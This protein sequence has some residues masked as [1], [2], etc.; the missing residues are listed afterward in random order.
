MAQT[1]APHACPM[2]FQTY[3]HQRQFEGRLA[4]AQEY[5]RA[6]KEHR[7]QPEDEQ[8]AQLSMRQ[9]GRAVRL[10][11]HLRRQEDEQEAQLLHEAD[12]T[13]RLAKL[14][15]KQ[16]ATFMLNC[17]CSQVYR[18]IKVAQMIRLCRS[19]RASCSKAAVQGWSRGRICKV[20]V[21]IQI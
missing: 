2:A 13:V 4:K 3:L 15:A 10:A 21:R 12:C 9:A 5:T 20:A 18:A 19:S 8:E 6:A 11:A 16:Q 14:T 7:R 1:C 17:K